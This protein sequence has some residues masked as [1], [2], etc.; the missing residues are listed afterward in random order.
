MANINKQTLRDDKLTEIRN[1]IA[2]ILQIGHKFDIS[3]DDIIALLKEKKEN[4]NG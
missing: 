3:A 4:R 1:N 2:K